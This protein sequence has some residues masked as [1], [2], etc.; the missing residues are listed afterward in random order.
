[1]A[2]KECFDWWKQAGG[3]DISYPNYQWYVDDHHMLH[4][5]EAEKNFYQTILLNIL[6]M[7]GK[8]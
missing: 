2:T 8:T 3:W 7:I 1:M 4:Y 5:I 6:L